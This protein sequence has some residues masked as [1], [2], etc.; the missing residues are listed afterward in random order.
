MSS[1]VFSKQM[2]GT[3]NSSS[4]FSGLRD[5]SKFEDLPAQNSEVIFQSRLTVGNECDLSRDVGN[6]FDIQRVASE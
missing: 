4:I 6:E 1:T 2:S 5:S 3:M